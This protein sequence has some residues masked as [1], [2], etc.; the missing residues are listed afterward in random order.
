MTTAVVLSRLCRCMASL[1]S[2]RAQCSACLSLTTLPWSHA[3]RSASRPSSCWQNSTC[4]AAHVSCPPSGG[5][6]VA[7]LA[8]CRER[9]N[10]HSGT[11]LRNLY[12]LDMQ[13]SAL[14]R[15]AVSP[16]AKAIAANYFSTVVL[17]TFCKMST[18]S[19]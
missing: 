4:A 16:E 7:K 19:Q 6:Y 1:T 5:G 8:F 18:D 15:L 11:P 3:S 13:S 12:L 10:A 9:R 2:A 17:L 14:A